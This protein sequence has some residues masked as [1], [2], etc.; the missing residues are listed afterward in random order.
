[1]LFVSLIIAQIATASPSPSAVQSP[2]PLKEIVRVHSSLLC[3]A[4]RNNLLPAAAAVRMNDSM[5]GRGQVILV[6]TADD[7]AAYAANASATDISGGDPFE[8]QA[9]ANEGSAS[10]TGGASA[11]SEM[12]AYQLG[13]LAQKLAKNI[14]TIEALLADPHAFPATPKNDDER[15]LVLAESRLEAVI[16]RQRESLNVLSGTAESNDAN[17]LKSRRDVIPYEHCM[18]CSQTQPS[19]PISMPS[20]LAATR[21][22]TEQAEDG[23]APAVLPIVAACK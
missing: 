18:S 8:Q 14:E 2:A 7:A 22:L 9:E 19:T 11:A 13:I 10:P 17:D 6:R 16:A 21:K 5:I 3:T 1:M 15:A 4:L 20:S 12:D 23:V